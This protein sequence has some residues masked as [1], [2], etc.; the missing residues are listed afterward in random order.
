MQAVVIKGGKLAHLTF[1]V[2]YLGETKET[3]RY[4]KRGP[5]VITRSIE[6]MVH[7]GY[8]YVITHAASGR[9]V[10]RVSKL[11]NA[12][13]AMRLLLPLTNWS[14]GRAELENDHLL[15]RRVRITMAPF[16]AYTVIV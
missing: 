3:T 10:T 5:L 13:K 14:R 9:A 6:D 15:A 4:S 2:E 8:P 16:D 12:R 11:A 7:L 1:H